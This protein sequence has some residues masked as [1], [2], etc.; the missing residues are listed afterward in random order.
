MSKADRMA[1]ADAKQKAEYEEWERQRA[2]LAP[3]P[4]AVCV[5]HALAYWRQVYPKQEQ[6][7]A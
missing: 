5:R 6:E 4:M 7:Q 3:K 2:L 1:K